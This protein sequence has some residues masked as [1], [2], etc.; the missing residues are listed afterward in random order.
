MEPWKVGI[1]ASD[2]LVGTHSPGFS[3]RVAE[4]A[5]NKVR[6][7]GRTILAGFLLV[8]CSAVGAQPQTLSESLDCVEQYAQAGT[9]DWDHWSALYEACHT[10]AFPAMDSDD[11]LLNK[12]KAGLCRAE[13]WPDLEELINFRNQHPTD[14]GQSVD[15][16]AKYAHMN[17]CDWAHWSEMYATCQTSSYPALHCDDFLLNRVK[18]GECTWG[19]WSNLFNQI[20]DPDLHSLDGSTEG[21]TNTYSVDFGKVSYSP[22]WEPQISIDGNMITV[23][24]K[25]PAMDCNTGATTEIWEIGDLTGMVMFHDANPDFTNDPFSM[26]SVKKV[27]SGSNN[28]VTGSYH[29]DGCGDYASKIT[30]MSISNDGNR[31]LIKLKTNYDYWIWIYTK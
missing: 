25:G 14:L 26:S 28:T 13:F 31:K 15:C 27:T 9:C 20:Y 30:D 8:V 7:V 4:A 23:T 24:H 17:I 12:V 3:L 29:C 22:S 10:Y 16:V 1:E 5:M 6:F 21:T 19:N 2:R 18:G 11:Y